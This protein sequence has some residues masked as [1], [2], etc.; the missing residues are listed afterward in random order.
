MLLQVSE[1]L[2]HTHG[3]GEGE[4]GDAG[5]SSRSTSHTHLQSFMCEQMFDTRQHVH[6]LLYEPEAWRTPHSRL[7]VS[8]ALQDRFPGGLGDHQTASGPDKHGHHECFMS[9]NDL[10][11]LHYLDRFHGNE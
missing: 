1:A 6:A 11:L 7:G 5:S 9:T 4:A 3:H 2:Q 8:S 10:E